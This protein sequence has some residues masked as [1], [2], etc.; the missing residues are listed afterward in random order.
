MCAA[1]VAQWIAHWTSNPEVA[2]S[3]PVKSVTGVR[4]SYAAIF[5]YVIRRARV[6]WPS[7]LRRQVKALISSGARVR[8]PSQP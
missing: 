2:G 5:L 1:L 6:E 3:N 4:A 8:I 7:G